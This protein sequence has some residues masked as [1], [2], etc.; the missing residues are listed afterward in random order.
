MQ[1]PVPLVVLGQ[2]R[3]GIRFGQNRVHH[4]GRL[5]PV[6]GG[7]QA[8]KPGTQPADLFDLFLRAPVDTSEGVLAQECVQTG[9]GLEF[10]DT[11]TE[12]VDQGRRLD[13]RDLRV[14]SKSHIDS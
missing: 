10:V 9:S 1:V 14:M 5:V 11:V 7:P 3:V 2:V 6:G 12:R 13:Q 4:G 8:A